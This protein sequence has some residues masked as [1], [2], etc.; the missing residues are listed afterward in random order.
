MVPKS[1]A[2]LS[3]LCL[4]FICDEISLAITDDCIQNTNQIDEF[5]RV[6]MDAVA[7]S[8]RPTTSGP[9]AASQICLTLG[10]CQIDNQ[11]Y[12]KGSYD[13]PVILKGHEVTNVKKLLPQDLGQHWSKELIEK[14]HFKLDITVELDTPTNEGDAGLQVFLKAVALKVSPMEVFIEDVF[15]YK[16]SAVLQSFSPSHHAA[17]ASPQRFQITK[18]AKNY[19]IFFCEIDW[20]HLCLQ[21]FENF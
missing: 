20:S 13:F 11:M 5:I 9:M 12:A 14:S 19:I 17:A 6:T 2:F 4:T 3:Q 10:D 21:N 18:N 1:N 8:I 15:M 16:M 7:F